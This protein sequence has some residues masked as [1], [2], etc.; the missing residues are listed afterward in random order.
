MDVFS[1]RIVGWCC[2]NHI[3]EELTLASLHSAFRTRQP[4][5]ELI[6]HTD[7]G[8][9]YAG[10]AYC[11]VLDRA[12]MQKSKSIADNCYANAFME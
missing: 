7:R 11:G 4:A 6:H 10:H 12:G 9:Q 2:A 3:R 5:P 8:G 1:R